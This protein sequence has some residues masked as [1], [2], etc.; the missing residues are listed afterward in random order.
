MIYS[1]QIIAKWFVAWAEADE[2]G[3]GN[4]TNLKLQKLL[5]YSQGHYL[6]Q[7]GEPLFDDRIQAW[8][9]G[10]VVASVYQQWKSEGAQELHLPDDDDFE[11]SDVDEDTTR[12]LFEIWNRYGS[13]AAWRLRDM[14][15]EEPPWRDVY[16]PGESGT[17]IDQEVMK[18]YFS[19]LYGK[20]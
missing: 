3:E 11:F 14:T 7:H 6:A 19:S 12:F 1:A 9:H 20:E 4:L 8:Q 10:P 17:V 2:D 18:K 13:L 5:Y 16:K 15:H